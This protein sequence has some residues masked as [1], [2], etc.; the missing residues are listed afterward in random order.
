[1]S[2]LFA[3][4]NSSGNALAAFENALTVSQNNVANAQT[5]GYARQS[6]SLE[7]QPF[8][9]PTGLTGGV[10]G[11]QTESARDTFAEQNVEQESTVLGQWNQMVSTLSPLQSNF[12]VTGQSGIPAA[13]SQFTSAASAW[14]SAPNDSQARQDVL[15]AAQG[16]AQAFN[17]TSAALSN[18]VTGADGQL[19]SLADQV[20]TLAAQIAKDNQMRSGAATPDP[21]VDAN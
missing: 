21:S 11:T 20:N 19:Q 17:S 10:T 14:S 4:I 18:A 15:T 2:N 6:L 1:M 12:D 9:I 3:A 16:I 7:A 8:D 13:L 5:P